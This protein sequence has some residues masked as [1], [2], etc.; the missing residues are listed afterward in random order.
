[1]FNKT[2]GIL[3]INQGGCRIYWTLSS[4]LLMHGLRLVGIARI[5]YVVGCVL[6]PFGNLRYSYKVWWWLCISVVPAIEADGV[7]MNE[8]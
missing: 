5:C 7:A 3:D 6:H 2:L 4:S 1:M 8:G